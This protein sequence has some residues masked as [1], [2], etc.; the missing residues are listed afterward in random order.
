MR[1]CLRGRCASRRACRHPF[2]YTVQSGMDRM[3][4]PERSHLKRW[5]IPSAPDNPLEE[6][7]SGRLLP[8]FEDLGV[9]ALS[10]FQCRPNWSLAT[11]ITDHPGRV[12]RHQFLGPQLATPATLEIHSR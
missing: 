12:V 1:G 5:A 7:S 11:Q 4:V 8:A 2:E 3:V 10:S 9:R 6:R